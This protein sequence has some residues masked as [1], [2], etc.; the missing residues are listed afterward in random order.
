[1][2]FGHRT[3]EEQKAVNAMHPAGARGACALRH[4]SPSQVQVQSGYCFWIF[5]SNQAPQ[6]YATSHVSRT[7]SSGRIQSSKVGVLS[8]LFP[9][10]A[11]E[12]AQNLWNQLATDRMYGCR[13]NHLDVQNSLA[14]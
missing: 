10:Y 8:L 2:K 11:N 5:L 9:N 4:C 3:L 13:A 14:C 6:L 1:M 7:H 12:A